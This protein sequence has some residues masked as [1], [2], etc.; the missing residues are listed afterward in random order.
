MSEIDGSRI[1]ISHDLCGSK[2]FQI[3]NKI[4]KI[5]KLNYTFIG[6]GYVAKENMIYLDRIFV[7]KNNH[8]TKLICATISHE[9]LHMVITNFI[10]SKENEGFDEFLKTIGRYGK[11]MSLG[12]I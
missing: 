3:K 6:G 1:D 5:L 2:Y 12:G 8:N 7:E 4:R 11:V 9:I 10:G